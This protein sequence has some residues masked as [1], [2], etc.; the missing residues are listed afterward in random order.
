MTFLF[1]YET[2]DDRIP[3]HVETFIPDDLEALYQ[4]FNQ[5]SDMPSAFLSPR[6]YRILPSNVQPVD[7]VIWHTC[8]V[9]TVNIM[10]RS[11]H[12]IIT[13][14]ENMKEATV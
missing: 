7:F 5:L 13:L 1:T 4:R 11:D 8:G 2:P 10:D 6:L 3:F 12:L 14:R 9:M